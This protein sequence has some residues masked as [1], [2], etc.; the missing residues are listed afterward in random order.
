MKRV[1]NVQNLTNK[2]YV[3]QCASDLDCYYGEG[4]TVVSS[5]TYDWYAV[6]CRTRP[7]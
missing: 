6:G 5:L 7:D 2:T 1:V 3:S 4:R